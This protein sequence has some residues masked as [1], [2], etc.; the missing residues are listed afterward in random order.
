MLPVSCSTAGQATTWYAHSVVPRALVIHPS[1]S[2]AGEIKEVLSHLA[3]IDIVHTEADASHRLAGNEYAVVVVDRKPPIDGKRIIAETTMAQPDAFI[4]VMTPDAAEGREF[5][6]EL[7]GKV[8]RFLAGPEQR[9]QLTGIVAEGLR[10]QKLEREQKQLINKLSAGIRQ[11][12]KAREAPRRGGQGAH[13]R[14]ADR[15]RKSQGGVA[16]GAA[17]PGRSHRGQGSVHQG[18]LRPHRRLLDGAG[19]GVRPL[20]D[21]SRDAGV[22]RLLARHRQDRR[23]RRGPAEAGCARRRRVE[24]HEDPSRGRVSDRRAARHAQAR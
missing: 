16:A 5:D 11:A 15:L 7:P 4:V 17:R 18:P 3:T 10:L 2:A 24:A 9:W 19:Q 23:A 14:A 12:A 6:M 1:P 22:R 21:R 20:R 8:F 13:A